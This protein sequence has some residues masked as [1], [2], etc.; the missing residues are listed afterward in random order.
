MTTV[1]DHEGNV[2]HSSTKLTYGKDQIEW[3]RSRVLE[4][5]SEGYTQREIAS[6]LQIGKGTVVNDLLYIRKQAQQNLQH[7]IHESLP[8]EYEKAMLG[9]KRNLRHALEIRESVLDPKI[10]LEAIRIANECYKFIMEL[11]TNGMVI[12]DAI[13]FVTQ[14]QQKIDTLQKLDECL[15]QQEEEEEKATEGVF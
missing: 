5:S 14:S 15:Q 8:D 3:R 10:K 12:S 9:T 11:S 1:E 7:H 2:D 6:K 13:K 4:L